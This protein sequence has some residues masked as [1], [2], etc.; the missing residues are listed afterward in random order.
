MV[1]EHRPICVDV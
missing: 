1:V